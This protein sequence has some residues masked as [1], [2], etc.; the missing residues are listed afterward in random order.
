MNEETNKN[1]T[2]K[3]TS[4]NTAKT[5]TK[6][7]LS[8]EAAKAQ[9]LARKAKEKERLAKAKAKEKEKQRLAKEKEKAREKARLA[10]EKEREKAKA[11]LAKE[12]EKAKERL[13]KDQEIAKAKGITVEEL[14][15]RRER[16]RQRRLE[17]LM[18]ANSENNDL[19]PSEDSVAIELNEEVLNKD[20][21]DEKIIEGTSIEDNQSEEGLDLEPTQEDLSDEKVDQE[22]VTDLKDPSEEVKVLDIEPEASENTLQSTLEINKNELDPK[23]FFE[24]KSPL[25]FKALD[26]TVPSEKPK[27]KGKEVID[28]LQKLREQIMSQKN[29]ERELLDKE[30]LN[31][32]QNDRHL[33]DK[34]SELEQLVKMEEFDAVNIDIQALEKHNNELVTELNQLQ[35]KLD[36][37]LN[38]KYEDLNVI[39]QEHLTLS[40]DVINLIN[41]DKINEIKSLKQK[42]EEVSTQYEKELADLKQALD[43]EKANNLVIQKQYEQEIGMQKGEYEKALLNAV[44]E[45]QQLLTEE[46]RKA[47]SEIKS[48]YEQA[49]NDLKAE[50]TS[51]EQAYQ[52]ELKQAQSVNP[53]VIDSLKQEIQDKNNT[54]LAMQ[55]DYSSLEVKNQLLQAQLNNVNNEI[56]RLHQE[57]IKNNEFV[58]QLM[59]EKEQLVNE[60]KQKQDESL[61]QAKTTNE[62]A[63][64]KLESQIKNLTAMMVAFQTNGKKVYQPPLFQYDSSGQNEQLSIFDYDQNLEVRDGF[65]NSLREARRVKT[66][67]P[68][69]EY[70]AKL[71]ALEEQVKNLST[72]ISV[73][74]SANNHQ[75][76]KDEIMNKLTLELENYKQELKAEL[77]KQITPNAQNEE[78]QMETKDKNVSKAGLEATESIKEDTTISKSNDNDVP[79]NE[80]EQIIKEDE[81]VAPVDSKPYTS[82]IANNYDQIFQ[83][84]LNNIYRLKESINQ[85]KQEE[86]EQYNVDKKRILDKVNVYQKSINDLNEQIKKLEIDYKENKNHSTENKNAF[87]TERTKLY[88]AI[89]AREDSL[90]KLREEDLRKL[91]LRYKNN[92]ENYDIQLRSLD[93]EAE[94][95]KT[96][97]ELKTQKQIN[98]LNREKEMLQKLAEEKAED[99]KVN[100]VVNEQEEDFE[101]EEP[102]MEINFPEPEVKKSTLVVRKPTEDEVPKN[103]INSTVVINRPVSERI[104]KDNL[105]SSVDDDSHRIIESQEERRQRLLREKQQPQAKPV[106][107]TSPDKVS[108][109]KQLIT[110]Y[111]NAEKQMRNEVTEVTK[112]IT[113][114][115][116]INDYEQA[117]LAQ[118]EAL[119]NL[120]REITTNPNDVELRNQ[121]KD[122]KVRND[123]LL[124]KIAYCKKQLKVLETQKVVQDYLRLVSKIKEMQQLLNAYTR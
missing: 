113:I 109:L 84:K 68:A 37:I 1:L 30:V 100:Q 116:E 7:K 119:A 123:N 92:C 72:M 36:E 28:N 25:S 20:G 10:R 98:R 13:K 107:S 17:K 77:A 53:E 124:A 35:N 8:P 121:Y 19:N 50:F 41:Q 104:S 22:E 106:T 93:E 88:L 91:D 62:D 27:S 2:E 26:N 47:L 95:L 110:K 63:I 34:L 43:L 99:Q 117:N 15:V 58:K 114:N 64:S 66:E 38:I 23:K 111:M 90:L 118:Q 31:A 12:K 75:S 52:D 71:H 69:E 97:Y 122:L 102:E 14:Y 103:V 82:I 74:V 60:L 86:T 46:H 32:Q 120:F 94:N 80:E 44:S 9:E 105:S 4:E 79:K 21:L 56:I 6:R 57:Q 39:D 51:K 96:I 55:K 108:E 16:A 3:K 18:N 24:S 81:I 54:I 49:F 83:N 61:S 85:K 115:R 42:L 112:L 48:S 73:I 5:P 59:Q 87:E 65:V 76:T 67:T 78:T 45:K 101:Y 70:Q 11:L 29:L 33:I 40:A 89:Q